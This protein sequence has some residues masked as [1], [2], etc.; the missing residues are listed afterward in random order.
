MFCSKFSFAIFLLMFFP[1]FLNVFTNILNIYK[2]P[3]LYN[4]IPKYC[5]T[6]VLTIIIYQAN[7]T[8]QLHL[9]SELNLYKRYWK[10]ALSG[11]GL[12]WH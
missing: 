8:S 2:L 9:A 3:E 1:L 12:F 5:Q 6:L 4:K 7:S 11:R 10:C